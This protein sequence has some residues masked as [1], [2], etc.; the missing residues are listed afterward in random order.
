MY[1]TM[2]EAIATAYVQLMELANRDP[3]NIGPCSMILDALSDLEVK[4]PDRTSHDSPPYYDLHEYFA[5]LT[6]LQK[7][8]KGRQRRDTERMTEHF[9]GN[10]LE[11]VRQITPDILNRARR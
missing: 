3:R 1:P 7:P 8:L 9:R 6:D 11:W 4:R 2:L 10:V 5:Y